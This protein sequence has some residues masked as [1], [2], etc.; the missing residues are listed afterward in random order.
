MGTLVLLRHGESVW[1][2]ENLFTGWV[3]VPLSDKGE[4]EALRGGELL[5]ETGLLPDIL[6]T[7][8]LRRAISTASVTPRVASSCR[9]PINMSARATPP[10]CCTTMTACARP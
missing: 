2:A 4:S 8:V 3:D 7:S 9:R 10:S 5:G 1:N 6:H